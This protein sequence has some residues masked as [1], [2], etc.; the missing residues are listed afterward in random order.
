MEV[1][2]DYHHRRAIEARFNRNFGLITKVVS[3]MLIVGLL[4]IGGM[5]LLSG[6]SI[7][8]LIIGCGFWFLVPIIWVSLRLNVLPATQNPQSI[9]DLLDGEVL[10]LLPKS[11]NPQQIV[12]AL[13]PT[14]GANFF[15]ARFGISLAQ[16]IEI[17]P[18]DERLTESVWRESINIWEHIVDRADTISSAIVLAAI[19]RLNSGADDMLNSLRIDRDDIFM[20]AA[21][22]EHLGN[23]IR[24]TDEPRLTGG[25]AR[26]WSFGYIPTLEH[27][28]VNLSEKYSHGSRSIATKLSRSQELTESMM[29]LLSNGTRRN[30]ALIGPFGTGKTTIVE[31]LAEQ[32]MDSRA[33]LPP[34]IRFNQIFMLD[35]SAIISAAKGRGQI[36]QLVNRLLV[37]AHKAKNIILFLDNADLFFEDATGA[38]D[39]S[40]LLQPALEGGVVKLILAMNEQRYLQ[41][42]HAN[43]ALGNALNRIEVEPTDRDDTIRVMEDRIISLEYHNKCQ[44]SYQ[45]LTEAFRLSTRYMDGVAQPRASIQLLENAT[46]QSDGGHITPRSIAATIEKTFGIKVG[47]DL[48]YSDS[49]EER[50][51]L[52]NLEKLIHERMIN[53][54]SAVSAVAGALRRARAGVR[55]ENRP[56]GTFLFLGPTGVGKTELAKALADV[57]FGGEDRMVRIDLNEYVRS[58]DVA[59]LIADGA[60]DP[61]SLSAQ[62]QKNPFSVV[63]LDEI[64]K[65]HPNVLTTLLQV[66]DEGVLRDINNR[67]ISFR[68]AILIATSNA[69]A[70]KIRQ[71]ID[72]GYQLEQFS[73]QIQ[74]ELIS[75]GQF[76]PEF[77]NRFDE[78]AVFRPLTKEELTQVIDLIMIGIN[79]N[80]AVQK[81][82]VAIDDGAKQV[83]VDAGY[84]PR[85]GARPM[86][87]VVQRSV[88]NIVAEKMLAGQL[89]PGS[90]IRLTADDIKESLK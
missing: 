61:M 74:D 83:L 87:R 20:G 7:G 40:N 50:Q 17:T 30:V 3:L 45:A 24:T 18:T 89:V 23:L 58:E 19:I 13:S 67:A 51:K 63:L 39:L 22:F 10:G 2:L 44:F 59:R 88:E 15:A 14:K 4:I 68:D 85:L 80:L 84:D 79:K 9:N 41:I 42:S 48:T 72:A 70:E 8:W 26:D 64:E 43:P 16:L 34:E 65:A 78:I 46:Q 81:V 54:S 53:Q 66:L 37:E 71:Y 75:S 11:P 57:Y 56:I 90:G 76:R 6:A 62:V 33:K 35:A 21:W 25:I 55:N 32:L 1:N 38:I 82:F 5:L 77:L 69:G 28:G 29:R 60:T 36:E 52:L 73:Q 49:T 27:F 12:K 86:R 31:S 47:G